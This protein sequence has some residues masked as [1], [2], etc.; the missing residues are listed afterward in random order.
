MAFFIIISFIAIWIWGFSFKWYK[1]AKIDEKENGYSF[2]PFNA[3]IKLLFFGWT[4]ALI[5]VAI[6]I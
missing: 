1:M 5:V 4:T 6:L 3:L 2:S